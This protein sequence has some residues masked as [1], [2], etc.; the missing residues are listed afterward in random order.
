MIA[1]ILIAGV[2]VI[3]MRNLN[4]ARG[5][6]AAADRLRKAIDDPSN[7]AELNTAIGLYDNARRQV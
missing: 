7:G 2:F 1:F 4:Q 6:I 3:V 5:C